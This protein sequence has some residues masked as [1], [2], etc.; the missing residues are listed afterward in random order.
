MKKTRFTRKKM[1][2]EFNRGDRFDTSNDQGNKRVIIKA[3]ASKEVRHKFS[4]RKR[5]T[6][7]GH[8]VS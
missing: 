1:T 6:G 8:G 7:S 3:K 2:K 4:V 5:T